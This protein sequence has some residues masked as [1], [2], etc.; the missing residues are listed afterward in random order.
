MDKIKPKKCWAAKIDL[1]PNKCKNQ[2]LI[3]NNV[4]ISL[5]YNV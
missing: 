5:L 2:E 1:I 4:I 3:N